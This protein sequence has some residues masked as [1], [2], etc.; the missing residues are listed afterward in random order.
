[1][2][3]QNLRGFTLIELLVVISIIGL[4]SSIVLTSLTEA[5]GRARDAKWLA[6]LK[7]IQTVMAA[8]KN[9][10]G[11]YPGDTAVV[12]GSNLFQAALNDLVEEGYF[13]ETTGVPMPTLNA[14]GQLYYVDC[15]HWSNGTEGHSYCPGYA[16]GYTKE[17][18]FIIFKTEAIELDLPIYNGIGYYKGS[19]D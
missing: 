17:G 13:D 14:G 2:K 5:R 10:K 18:Y 7:Q 16:P 9:D 8:Y 3:S 12:T 6:E 15:E 19:F 4:L 1:M 11:F